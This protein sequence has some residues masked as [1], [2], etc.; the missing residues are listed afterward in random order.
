MLG[1]SGSGMPE[2]VQLALRSTP[3]KGEHWVFIEVAYWSGI[4]G[5]SAS[6]RF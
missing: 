2:Q 6:V 5:Y 4:G 3:E 1:E